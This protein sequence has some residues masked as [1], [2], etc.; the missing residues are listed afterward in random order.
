MAP[1]SSHLSP[2]RVRALDESQGRR[3]TWLE[4]FFDLEFVV[5]V[6]QLSNALSA[7]KI[8]GFSIFCGLFAPVS[9]A[10]VGSGRTDAITCPAFG[11]TSPRGTS[12]HRRPGSQ[13]VYGLR[14]FGTSAIELSAPTEVIPCLRL[15]GRSALSPNGRG[16][17]PGR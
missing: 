13:E 10:W 12:R 15:R 7:D 1:H 5:A 16:R 4:L 14:P 9:W 11:V 17:W 6:A 3:V 2:P 8:E